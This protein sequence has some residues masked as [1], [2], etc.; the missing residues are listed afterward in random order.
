MATT[1]GQLIV[2]DCLPKEFRDYT[3]VLD[4]N[5][6]EDLLQRVASERP[7]L[8]S[9]ITKNLMDIGN[10]AAFDTG[11]TLRLSDCETKF[12]KRPFLKIIS[13]AED[14]I[15]ADT[16]LSDAEKKKALGEVYD[17]V[18]ASIEKQVYD[19]EL[20]AHN[21]LALQVASKARGNKMQLAQFISTPGSFPDNNGNTVPMFIQHSF[22]EGLTPAEYWAG[23]Y[24]TRTSTVQGKIATAKGGAFGKLLSQSA[25]N[26]V[27][28]EDDCG[29]VNGVP[30]PL[31]DDDNL[32]AVLAVKAGKYGA[33]TIITK[34]VLSDLR[35]NKNI[36][37]IVIRSPMTCGCKN[38]VCSKCAGIRET[39]SFPPIGYN[40]GTN[41]ASAFAERITQGA[42]NCLAEGTL[43]RMADG[44]TKPI[45]LINP[46]DMVFGSS[47][48][49]EIAPTKVLNFFDQGIQPCVR[50]VFSS[51]KYA[52]KTVILESTTEHP[53]L[54]VTSS[55]D[56]KRK[57][58]VGDPAEDFI[59]YVWEKGPDTDPEEYQRISQK[60]IGERHV[61]DIEVACDGHLFLLSNGLDVGNTKHCLSEGTLVRMADGTTKAIECIHAGD[62]VIGSDACGNLKPVVVTD[63]FDNGIE[64]CVRTVFRKSRCRSD[65]EDVII[66]STTEHKILGA[67]V[68][69]VSNLCS[70]TKS[71]VKIGTKA[72]KFVASLP[73]SFDDTG[74]INEPYARILGVL[75][76]DGCYTKSVTKVY[77]SCSDET[78][79]RELNDYLKPMGL[80]LHRR[81]Y[82]SGIY[83]GLSMIGDH[84]ADNLGN[85]VKNYLI[86]H[87]MYGKY[88]HDKD[89]P[90]VVWSWDNQSVGDL[91][92]G[93]ISADGSVCRSSDGRPIVAI[94]ST[95]KSM[96]KHMQELLQIRFGI[97]TSVITRTGKTGSVINAV[98]K[99][100]GV[101][102]RKHDQYQMTIS[103]VDMLSRVLRYIHI[104]GT[105][106]SLLKEYVDG[107]LAGRH[108]RPHSNTMTRI[109]QEDIG[110]RHVYD[111]T[112]DC[113]DHLFL[114]AN[115][116]IV[117]N[118]G[119]LASGAGQYQGFSMFTSLA[120]VPKSYP[121]KATLSSVDGEVVDIKDAPQGGK[122]IFISDGS[123]TK[124]HYVPTGYDV[125]VK[126]GDQV[127]EGDQLSDGVINPAELVHYKGIGEARR[128]WAKRFTQG[129]RDSGMKGNRRNAEVLAKTLINNV[130]LED[131][132]DV[133]LPGDV[134]TYTKW[135][136]G[137]RPR[138]DTK[139]LKPSAARGMFLEQPVL[140]YTIGTRIT[141][142][143]IKMMDKFGQTQ[144]FA[145]PKRPNVIPFM[146]RVEDSNAVRDDW[147][148]RLST[149]Y[150]KDRLVEDAQRGSVS[151]LHSTEPSPGLA[152]GVEFGTWGQP[153]SNNKSTT[154]TY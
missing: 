123:T 118:S 95:S 88:A 131:E 1:V 129:I 101:Y 34:S 77:V 29:G 133:G 119:R 117:S 30:M 12:D 2:N 66:E 48:T 93:F 116:L 153:G 151:H 149:T 89:I 23:S 60:S 41:A 11:V 8:Y 73:S 25:N 58:K 19:T 55:N 13:D 92:G 143:V 43:V 18:Q 82:H 125:L 110:M 108:A 132:S 152:K 127:E 21:Q 17:K 7:E 114:L 78:T 99:E 53:V 144:I 4:S 52:D 130:E 39:G 74:M 72:R 50:T 64:P 49:G 28:V 141:P 67:K 69:P 26:Q 44:T 85:P 24:G 137:Y 122:Y 139:I 134:T 102:Y 56:Q 42:L 97:S 76:G 27:I 120:K 87:G 91:L 98:E 148:A 79:I 40:L 62:R 140:H 35:R 16:S 106:S 31:D 46:G 100:Y 142:S 135:A 20:K 150:L 105:K 36:D 38:G 59:T 68:S 33:G 10:D 54:G 96:L 70:S 32:G 90:S 86:K 138:K 115:G 63:T 5:G 103:N 47:L 136:F 84:C 57:V 81:K 121:D 61:Y 9:E 83:Y 94:A 80:A 147:M 113:P 6:L 51:L 37:E 15:E 107:C 112:V 45:E 109:V 128:Y 104:P 71:P 75:L 111:I 14:R 65:A 3:R 146:Q 126:S 145:N 22:A 154:F 124:E